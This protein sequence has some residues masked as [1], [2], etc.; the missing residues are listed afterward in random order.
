MEPSMRR[1]FSVL[2]C[3]ALLILPL[4]LK[5]PVLAET[6]G[7]LSG[8]Q[9]AAPPQNGEMEQNRPERRELREERQRLRA[10]HEQ[11]EA[12]HDR[13][14]VECM[15]AKGQDRSACEDKKRALHEQ[16]E[17]LHKRMKEFHEKV[18]AT[19][20]QHPK[21]PHHASQGNGQAPVGSSAPQSQN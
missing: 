3:L 2:G 6:A 14:K 10:E 11:L 7:A 16:K 18:E 12:E 15:D 13:L 8:Q 20:Q 17:D 1:T 4:L 9:Q 21:S 19:R 5:A